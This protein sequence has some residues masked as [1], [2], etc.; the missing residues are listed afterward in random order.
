MP[1]RSGRKD[2]QVCALRIAYV[3]A[4]LALGAAPALAQ[5]SL[6]NP[7]D[8]PGAVNP[9][10]TQE[11]IGETICLPGWARTV[12]PRRGFTSALK[13][14]QLGAWVAYAGGPMREYEE[15]HLIPLELGGAPADQRNLWPEPREPADGWG[16]DR[17]DDLERVLHGLVCAGRLPLALAQRS[18][19]RDWVATYRQFVLGAER[20]R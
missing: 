18:I 2:G 3:A 1:R 5:R 16:A 14:W 8:T 19:A 7:L 15:D 12:R 11:N 10:V 6:P 4:V 13:R 20:V 17:K 9:A